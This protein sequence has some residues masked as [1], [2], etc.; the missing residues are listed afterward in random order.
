MFVREVAAMGVFTKRSAG[1]EA[2]ESSVA[3]ARAM[4]PLRPAVPS[5]ARLPRVDTGHPA[6]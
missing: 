1:P 2:E 3:A 4:A 5:R 6:G